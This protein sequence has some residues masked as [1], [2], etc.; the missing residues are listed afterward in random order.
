M[1]GNA[2]ISCHTPALGRP[3]LVEALGLRDFG[4]PCEYNGFE[5]LESSVLQIHSNGEG[6]PPR[7]DMYLPT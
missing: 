6:W 5:C 2:E 7:S 1:L 3:C 4:L